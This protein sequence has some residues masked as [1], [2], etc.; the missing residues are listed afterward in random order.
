MSWPTLVFLRRCE[1]AYHLNVQF[2]LRTKSVRAVPRRQCTE[3]CILFT[4]PAPL[5][6]LDTAV[7]RLVV[8]MCYHRTTLT[9][10]LKIVA[11]VAP[12]AGIAP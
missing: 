2:T 11:R 10:C 12:P 5:D 9:H 7:K 1:A 4:V 6:Y 3:L 8:L